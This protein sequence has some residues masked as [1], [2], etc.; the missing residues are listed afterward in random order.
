MDTTSISDPVLL[1]VLSTA[2]QTRGH[3]LDILSFLSAHHQP[4]NSLPPA[5]DA[6]TLAKLQKDLTSHLTLLRGRHRAAVFS[7]RETKQ[8][9]ASSRSEIDTLHLTLQ[10]LFYEQRHLEGEIRA[11]EEYPHA[12]SKLDLALEEDFLERHPDFSGV[13]ERTEKSGHE[14]MLARI[15]DEGEERRRLEAE[16]VGLVKRKAELVKANAK[17]KEELEKLDREVEGWL[18]GS[19]KIRGMLEEKLKVERGDDEIEM[20]NA[21][22]T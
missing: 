8:A 6:R 18:E 10:N 13:G 21:S 17:Q 16:R 20:G 11:C 7:V 12:F 5:E 4:A 2:Q 3:C 22:S 14:M 19:G 15:R 9:T 1:S